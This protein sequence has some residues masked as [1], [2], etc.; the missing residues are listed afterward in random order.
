MMGIPVELT[1]RE[2]LNGL[3]LCPV[4]AR[5]MLALRHKTRH[6]QNLELRPGDNFVRAAKGQLLDIAAEFTARDASLIVFNL[7]GRRVTYDFS[8][9][10]IDCAG[11]KSALPLKAGRVRL[12]ILV[13]RLSIDIFG[14]DGELYMPMG[15]V[16][17][18]ANSTLEVSSFKGSTLI[19]SLDVS[20][21]KSAWQ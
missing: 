16:I 1:L 4:P 14:N 17:D 7:F 2:G 21:L 5:E 6:I 20:E 12:R 10:Q 15:V 18:P 9:Q 19:N 8:D 11:K 3:Q 13:D